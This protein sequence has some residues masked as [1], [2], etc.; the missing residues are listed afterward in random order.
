MS[1]S[2]KAWKVFNQSIADYHT[3]DEIG[4]EEQNP[5]KEKTLENLLYSKNWID[6][7]Q[8]HLEDLIR[9][10]NIDPEYALVLKRLIDSSNQKR[11]D[12]VEYIDEW[13]FRKYK[14]SSL[15]KKAKI[16]TET[17]A[18]AVDR[19]SILA[20]KIYHMSLE[21]FRRSATEEHRVTCHQKLLILEEQ[22]KDLSSAIDDLLVD[23]KEGRVQIKRYK[24]MKMYNDKEL[25]PVLYQLKKNE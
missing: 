25:N 5:Y 7:V 20:L 24:Q 4:T 18:W 16:N 8:W 13:F 1:F 23:I 17:P 9:E 21:V 11:T 15:K 2:E 19:L 6:T 3:K 10:E 22:K 14:S 12:A